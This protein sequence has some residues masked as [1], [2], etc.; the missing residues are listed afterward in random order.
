M[1]RYGPEGIIIVF[2]HDSAKSV[3]AR[4][5]VDAGTVLTLVLEMSE[6]LRT[7]GMIIV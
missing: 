3:F 6:D 7:Y 4:T 1:T 2:L 5:G